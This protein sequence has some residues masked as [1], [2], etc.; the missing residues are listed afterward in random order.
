LTL[1]A[2]LEVMLIYFATS[3]AVLLSAYL[4]PS[5]GEFANSVPILVSLLLLIPIYIW[6]KS[7]SRKTQLSKEIVRKDKGTV[8]MW[9]LALF[10]LALSIRIPSVLLYGIPLE[11]TPVILLTI[12]TILVIEKTDAYAFGFTAKRFGKSL[13]HGL[14][15]FV[16]FYA[17]AQVV[18]CV[19]AYAFTS[20][21]LVQSYNPMPF[22]LTLPFMTLCVGISEEGLFR[23]YVQTHLEKPF[24]LRKAIV[25]QALLFG[26]WHFV[27]NLSPLDLFAMAQYVGVT[28]FVG[29]LFGYFYSK[30]KNLTPVVFAHGLWDSLPQGMV[31][32]KSAFDAI[33][34]LPFSSQALTFA[35]PYVVATLLTV[36]FIKHFVKKIT[37]D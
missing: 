9:I 28:F 3:F 32:N 12:L 4:F 7:Y 5:E 29:L 33:G 19:L 6:H 14:S 27:W 30:T 15:F 18:S 21:L 25:I 34:T 16:L 23:G 10:L 2:I 22:L 24:T 31:Q 26:V 17:V 37:V 13:L 11:K 20:Q 8:L 1:K 36:F 35:L